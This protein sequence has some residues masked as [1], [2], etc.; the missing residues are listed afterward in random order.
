M[1]GE[2]MPENVTCDDLYFGES[3]T[4][5]PTLLKPKKT[6][7]KDYPFDINIDVENYIEKYKK[8]KIKRKILR[9]VSKQ[10]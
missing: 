3:Q 9:Y 4:V 7:D 6:E 2:K 10:D 8:T 5:V 1:E